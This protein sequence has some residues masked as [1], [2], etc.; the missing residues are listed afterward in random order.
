MLYLV[1]NAKGF[2]VCGTIRG[3]K[4]R[5]I[6]IYAHTTQQNTHTYIHTC[7]EILRIYTHI[8]FNIYYSIIHFNIT[9]TL[10]FKYYGY[11]RVREKMKLRSSYSDNSL[12]RTEFKIRSI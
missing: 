11:F 10:S 7:G 3:L 4:H 12:P 1:S 6:Y 9:R 2:S 8:Y 5:E